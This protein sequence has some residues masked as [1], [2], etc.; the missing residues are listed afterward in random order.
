MHIGL[1]AMR[2]PAVAVHGGAHNSDGWEVDSP[3]HFHDMH[4][5]LYAFAGSVDVEGEEGSHRIPNQFAAWI[6]AGATHR[7]RIQKVR[8]GSVFLSAELVPAAGERV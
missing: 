1:V 5:L 2:D 8:S 7:T 3:W 4:Q 6:P